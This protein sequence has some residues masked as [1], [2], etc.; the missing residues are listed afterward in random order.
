MSGLTMQQALIT[1]G[2]IYEDQTIDINTKK[3]FLTTYLTK[4]VS[5]HTLE[6]IFP[7]LFIDQV[8]C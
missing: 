8:Q 7:Y 6:T 1:L 2:K 4:I 3:E 5:S